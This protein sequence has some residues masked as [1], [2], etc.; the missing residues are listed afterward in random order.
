MKSDPERLALILRRRNAGEPLRAIAKDLGVTYQRVHQLE[1]LARRDL[2]LVARANEPE[3]HR[4][5]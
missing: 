2:L 4:H 1:A 3:G 5:A